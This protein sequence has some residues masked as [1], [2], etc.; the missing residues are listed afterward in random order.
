[1]WSELPLIPRDRYKSTGHIFLTPSV[2]FLQP[3]I[4]WKGH[5]KPSLP[6]SKLC[7]I[8]SYPVR[9]FQVLCVRPVFLNRGSR[10]CWEMFFGFVRALERVRGEESYSFVVRFA[11]WALR[12]CDITRR[13][14]KLHGNGVSWQTSRQRLIARGWCGPPWEMAPWAVFT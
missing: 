5:L 10:G 13:P 7:F 14:A 12:S 8:Y 4:E 11:K 2:C 6:S 9:S 1:M 3:P